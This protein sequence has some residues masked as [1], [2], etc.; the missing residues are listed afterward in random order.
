MIV[1]VCVCVYVCVCVRV[2]VVFSVMLGLCAVGFVACSGSAGFG[3]T[4]V[5][6]MYMQCCTVAVVAV[7]AS[8]ASVWCTKL[9]CWRNCCATQC[10]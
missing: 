7:D 6:H 10:S 9:R 1:C 2:C 4:P 3:S 5:S 8:S